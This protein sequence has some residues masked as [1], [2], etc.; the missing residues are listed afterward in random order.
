MENW[1]QTLLSQYVNARA[2]NSLISSF[3]AAID[4]SA[5]ISAFLEYIWNVNTA[6]GN[7]LDIWGRIVGVSR[8]IQAL[9]GEQITLLDPDFKTLILVKSAA[10]IGNVTVP[11]LNSLLSQIFASYG[12]VYVQDNLNM[13][14]TYVFSF[15]PTTAQQ[16]IVENSGVMPRPAGVEVTYQWPTVP[17]PVFG[18]DSNNS[19]VAGFDTGSWASA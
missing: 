1:S 8:N 13:T 10:N 19:Y 5:N 14:L 18:F 4:P 17:G 3:N 2:L 6:V 11:T 16:A 12:D 9:T 7:G 15:P